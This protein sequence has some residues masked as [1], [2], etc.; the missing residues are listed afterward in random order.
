[1]QIVVDS[2]LTHYEQ[3]GSGKQ[4][5]V[6]VHGWG[7][8]LATF[9][10]LAQKLSKTYTVVTVDLPGFGTTQAPQDIWGL[11][12]YASFIASF[13]S[14]LKLRVHVFIGHSNG[15]SVLIKGLANNTLNCEKLVLVASA[16]IRDQEKA[17]RTA[18][19]VIAKSGK[20]ATF[21]LPNSQKQKLRKKL[22]GTIG[23]DL[24]VAPHM[25]ETFKRTV[26]Q[27]VQADARK[28]SVPTLLIYGTKDTATPVVYGEIYDQ[29]INN[30][31]LVKIENASH[32]VHQENPN[33]VFNCIKD[34]LA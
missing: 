20:A 16:G 17:K 33:E 2:L 10:V 6:M 34:F 12:E 22:Y 21:W 11:E 15:G 8:S 26:R 1:M 3:T 4:T 32:F 25:Q 24:M 19:K 23:S 27:D 5:V 28:L 14:K 30:S 31:T 7:D 18:L 29:L 13:V 9:D